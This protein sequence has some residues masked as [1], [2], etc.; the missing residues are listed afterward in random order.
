MTI[1]EYGR[2][3]ASIVLVQPVGDHNTVEIEEEYSEIARLTGTDFLFLAV[4]V[5]DWNYDLSPWRAA[6]VFGNED[7]GN[8]ASS[9]LEFIKAQCCDR[10]RRYYIGGYSLAGLFALWSAF[11]TD[12]FAGVAAASP[13]VWFPGFVPYMREHAIKSPVVCLSLGDRE[14][15]TRNHLMSTVADCITQCRDILTEQNITCTLEW[16]PGNH[17]KDPGLR[18]AKAFAWV[19]KQ[20]KD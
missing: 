2:A 20:D 14:A 5:D 19:M 8:G 11:Q 9:T 3:D 4:N 1:Y 18:T 13:S 6:A 16:D 12:I 15:K 17:F 7:F 10:N